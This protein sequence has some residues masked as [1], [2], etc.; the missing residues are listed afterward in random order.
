MLILA[1]F[2]RDGAGDSSNLQ[3]LPGHDK[4]AL[5]LLGQRALRRPRLSGQLSGEGKP[6]EFRVEETEG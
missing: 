3:G 2:R 1:L 5:G 6:G 4:M